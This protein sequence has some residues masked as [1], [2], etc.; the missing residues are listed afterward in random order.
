MPH[1]T[2]T[3]DHVVTMSLRWEWA[4]VLGVL[5]LMGLMSCA[6]TALEWRDALLAKLR[7]GA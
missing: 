5:C 3:V 7:G 4:W 1:L 6:F 2:L